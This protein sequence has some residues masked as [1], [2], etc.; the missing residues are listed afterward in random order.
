MPLKQGISLSDTMVSP[1]PEPGIIDALDESFDNDPIQITVED[2]PESVETKAV[3]ITQLVNPKD[4]SRLSASERLSLIQ[5]IRRV[6]QDPYMYYTPNGACEEYIKTIGNSRKNGK[7]IFLF[8]A[9]NGV[10]KTAAG[11]NIMANIFYQ[12]N[13]KW[14]NY[15]IFTDRWKLPKVFWFITKV[16]TLQETIEPE[17]RKWFPKNRYKLS[18]EGKQH[19]YKLTTDTGFTVFFK[20]ID[21]NPETFESATLGG[22]I[23]DEPPPENIHQACTSRL[24]AGGYIFAQLT[25]LHR[26]AWILDKWMLNDKVQPYF[27]I[28][29]ADIWANSISKGVRGRLRESDIEFMIS[30]LDPNEYD[31]RVKGLFT[32]LRGLVYKDFQS[33]PPYVIDPVDISNP[34]EFQIY[35]VM[36]PHDRR[37]PAIG[38]YAVDR[39]NQSY[40]VGEWPNLEQF[41]GRYYEQLGD[42]NYTFKE[43]IEIIKEIEENNKWKVIWRKIDPNRGKTPYGNSG[44]TVQEEFEKEGMYF[45]TDVQDDLT[46]GHSVVRKNL[47]MGNLAK[48]QLQVFNTCKNHIW[49]FLRYVYDENEGKSA[50]KKAT[51]ENVLEKGKDFMDIVRY[52]SVGE[53]KFS[54]KLPQVKGWR[55]KLKEKSAS[56]K[57]YMAA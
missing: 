40:V 37:Y 31:A 45:D 27:Y 54:Y 34:N 41:N 48:P 6:E 13:T 17:I 8:S 25:P 10:G 23:Y 2:S 22:I 29:Y 36:D 21:Q 9:A 53:H 49:S 39:A 47:K 19:I 38:W 15:P 5:L 26:A 14:F 46:V 12:A 50:Q 43:I 30:Q 28:Q 3:G 44:L 11:V 33:E 24:R 51:S 42:N 32:H 4:S 35:C 20:T 55:K 16:S 56:G 18:N 52:F 7:R 57:G 1:S